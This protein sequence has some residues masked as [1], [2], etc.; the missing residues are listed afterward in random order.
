METGWEWKVTKR[1]FILYI[2]L[3]IIHIEEYDIARK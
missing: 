3:K 1:S 2:M